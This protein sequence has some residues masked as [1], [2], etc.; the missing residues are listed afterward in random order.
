MSTISSSGD[1]PLDR[2]LL[3]LETVLAAG[4]P[5]TISEIAERIGLP[6]PTVHRLVAQLNSRGM[7]K[8]AIG[9]KRVLPGPRLVALGASILEAAMLADRPHTILMRLAMEVGEHCQIGIVAEGEVLYVDTARV[10]QPSGL[11]FQPGRHAPLHCTSIGKL[12]LA[13]LPDAQLKSWMDGAHFHAYTPN[14]ILD[15]IRLRA[16][17]REIRTSGWAWNNE[18][19]VTGVVGCAVPI[20]TSRGSFLAG[21]GLAGPTARLSFDKLK[22][23]IPRLSTAAQD[24]ANALA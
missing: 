21:L 5:T 16:A 6:T 7:L 14:T 13:S 17:I 15:Q 24:I 23:L 4:E 12:F 20:Q 1:Q 10:D 2:A 3:V 19:Y 9:S 11:H 8:R 18:E 22:K